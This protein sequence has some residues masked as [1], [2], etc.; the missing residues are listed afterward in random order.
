MVNIEM[1]LCPP[2][3]PGL[4]ELAM[5]IISSSVAE[6]KKIDWGMYAK[7]S[8]WKLLALLG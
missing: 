8:Q 6:L 5:L 1:L 4:N 7:M 2:A 3:L